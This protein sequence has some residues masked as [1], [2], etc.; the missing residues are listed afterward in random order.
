MMKSSREIINLIT[1]I[2]TGSVVNFPQGI[3]FH[4]L[5]SFA[6]RHQI[7]NV[8]YYALKKSKNFQSNDV[9]N[10]ALVGVWKNAQRSEKQLKENKILCDALTENKIDFM[11]VKGTALKELYPSHEL[12]QMADIDILIRIDQYKKIAPIM[13]ALGYELYTE[14]DHEWT[15]IKGKG[16]CVELHKRLIPSYNKDYYAFFGDGWDKAKQNKDNPYL[17]EM[18]AEDNFVYIFTHFAKHYRDAGIGIKHMLDLWVYLN[19]NRDMN[20]NYIK[21]NLTDLKLYK[22]YINIEY[23]LKTWFE[24]AK[25]TKISKAITDTVFESGSYGLKSNQV[26]SAALK[27]SNETKSKNQAK[28]KHIF[29]VVFL[30]KEQLSKKY[31]SLNKYPIL[32]PFFWWYRATTALLFRRHNIKNQIN[33]VKKI[34]SDDMM[35]YKK[36]LNF[37]GLDF[38]FSED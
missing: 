9:I 23:T 11:P 6:A 32:L 3:D 31:P 4:A 10:Q 26:L 28:M 13:E 22:F 35:D 18:S 37:V 5:F 24:G 15:W 33:M 7:V 38:N 21:K 8:I 12:R 34:K 1:S 19:A 20:K 14:S 27:A 30:S 16:I 17:Y 36:K 29:K 2:F 25:E